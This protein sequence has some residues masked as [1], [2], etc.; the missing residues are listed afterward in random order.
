M[1]IYKREKYFVLIAIAV[2]MMMFSGILYDSY[3]SGK[4]FSN[5]ETFLVKVG[6]R[7]QDVKDVQYILRKWGYFKGRI[8]GIFG[9]DTKAS[10]I[11]FQ[12]KNGLTPDGVVGD[13]TA[14]AL[15]INVAAKNKTSA[16]Q[17]TSRGTVTRKNDL[18][19]LAQAIH[20]EARGEPY[21]GQVAVGAVIL[22]RVD[23]P[24]FPKTIA[25]I[26]YQ[27]GAFTAVAD[28][29]I[30]LPPGDSAT[31]AARDAL[32]GWDPSGGAMYYF[33]PAKATNK[34][35]WSRPIIKVIGK[36]YFCR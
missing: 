11:S 22:N 33:N 10:V 4:L 27:P 34:W 16:K 5:I 36:H 15:G 17:T 14:S 32:N 35:I 20:G 9:A 1:N 30:N 24:K 31:K 12:K 3:T 7:G 28:G 26:I 18:Y 19:L 25:G 8:D 21:I 2:L 6:S 23:D 13:Q 29:Q